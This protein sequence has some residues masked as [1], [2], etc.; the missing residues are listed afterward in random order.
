ML[1]NRPATCPASSS[2]ASGGFREAVQREV[3]LPD[4]TARALGATLRFVYTDEGPE[5]RS[6]E[7]AEELLAAASKLGIPGMLR[8]CSDYLR[9]NWLTVEKCCSLLA[10]ADT[11][12]ATSLR[13][14]A[15]AVL[16][17]NFDAVKTTQ[18]YH[19]LLLN[20]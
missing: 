6:R 10:L 18:E 1:S 8:L 9:D 12:G 11:H 4:I 13:A 2:G 14:E 3:P 16:G 17:S 7:E 19:H 5:M 20:G 15:L